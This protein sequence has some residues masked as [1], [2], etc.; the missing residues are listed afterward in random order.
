MQKNIFLFILLLLVYSACSQSG[1][2]TGKM[3][4]RINHSQP[5]IVGHR[6]GFDTILPENSL[7]L[8]DFTFS[9]ACLKPFAIEFDIRKSASGS[10]FIMHDSNVDRTTNGHGEIDLLT[11]S[12]LKNLF[13]RDRN[14]NLTSEKVPL[15]ADVLQHF[16]EKNI[17]LM[18]DVKGSLYPDVIE[19]INQMHMESK[20]IILTFNP[21]NTRL[22]K[23]ITGSSMIS[24]LVEN[25]TDWENLR[26]LKIPYWQLIAYVNKKTPPELITEINNSKVLLI[27]DMSESIRNNSKPYEPDNY[28]AIITRMH[29][30]ILITDFP[31]FV[32]QLFCE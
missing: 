26:K 5:L 8:F 13:L 18:L 21:E 11:D 14:G 32:N 23:G 2:N 19:L 7:A 29:S 12:Y 9:N 25:K 15:F 1:T 28:K 30:G 4:K 27:T 24:A 6:G 16:H 10:L 22:V 3:N 20:C 31:L 17:I